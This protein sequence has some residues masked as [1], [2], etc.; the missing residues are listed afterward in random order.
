MRFP[1]WLQWGELLAVSFELV[2]KV[3]FRT[4]ILLPVSYFAYLICAKKEL[5]C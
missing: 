3:L 2:C 1:V 5:E 4:N